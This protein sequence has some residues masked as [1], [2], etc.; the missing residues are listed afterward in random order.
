MCGVTGD[1]R[2]VVLDQFLA[3]RF[4]K[5]E[6]IE[7]PSVKSEGEKMMPTMHLL[8]RLLTVLYLSVRTVQYGTPR[9]PTHDVLYWLLEHLLVR[10]FFNK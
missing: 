6:K 10:T 4:S 1:C 7:N 5:G 9:T 2:R 8:D 3:P